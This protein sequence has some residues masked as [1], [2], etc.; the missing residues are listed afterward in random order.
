M[1]R[2]QY[3]REKGNNKYGGPLCC[4]KSCNASLCP[5]PEPEVGLVSGV[6][7]PTAFGK[8]N[9]PTCFDFLVDWTSGSAA[10]TLTTGNFSVKK[11]EAVFYPPDGKTYAY[12]DVVDFSD[13]YCTH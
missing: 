13:L 3:L 11:F 10:T 7:D 5:G 6:K 12:V 2:P 1:A 8:C 4:L 9:D